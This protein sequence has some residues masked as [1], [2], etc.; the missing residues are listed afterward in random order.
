MGVFQ[1][2]EVGLSVIAD[3]LAELQANGVIPATHPVHA[4]L[5]AAR[6][7]VSARTGNPVP[8]VSAGA[9]S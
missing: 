7:A 5:A 4:K 3:I 6:A 2:I 1:A 9:K 8:T